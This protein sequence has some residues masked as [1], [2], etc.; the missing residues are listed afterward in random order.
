MSYLFKHTGTEE[1]LRSDVVVF[2][3]F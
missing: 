2:N 3:E 1:M